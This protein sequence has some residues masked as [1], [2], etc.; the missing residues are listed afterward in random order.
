MSRPLT[1]R[2]P[3]AKIVAVFAVIFGVSLGLCGL[4]W[5]LISAGVDPSHDSEFNF[6]GQVLGTLG[7]IELAAMLL[8]ALGLVL[9]VIIWL[10][11]TAVGNFAPHS[12]DPQK[13]FD[14]SGG[15]KK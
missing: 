4:N 1:D 13:L 6:G 15:N 8:S 9:T 3:F 5:V 10:V 7:L 2:V 11:A 14:D 12:N